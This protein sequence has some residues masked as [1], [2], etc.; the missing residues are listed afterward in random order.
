MGM[1]SLRCTCA[2]TLNCARFAR[3]HA[4]R[5]PVLACT[6]HDICQSGF[7]QQQNMPSFRDRDAYELFND[8]ASEKASEAIMTKAVV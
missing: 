6:D 1:L 3:H 5:S 2:G 8:T 7:M 4:T